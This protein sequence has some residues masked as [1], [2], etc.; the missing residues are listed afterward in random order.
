VRIRRGGPADVAAVM[1]FFDEAVEWMVGRGQ[2]GQWGAEPLSANPRMVGRVETWAAAERSGDEGS[3]RGRGLWM[4]EID[5]PVGALV[6]GERPDHVEPVDVDELYIE[7]LL[8]SRRYAGQ[9][10]GARLVEHARGLAGGRLLRVD[11]WAGAPRLVQFY[12][13]QGFVKSGTFLVGDWQGQ[14]FSMEA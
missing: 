9:R 11:C 6:V 14:V 13:D 8:S 5:E 12:E 4:A 7:L 2:T 10:I 3:A 1:G